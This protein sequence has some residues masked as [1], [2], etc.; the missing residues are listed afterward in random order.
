VLLAGT[1]TVVTLAVGTPAHADDGCPNG[2]SCYYDHWGYAKIWTAPSCGWFNLGTFVPPL[3]DRISS[4][5]NRGNGAVQGYNWTGSSWQPI[6]D[7][8]AADGVMV[9][10]QGSNNNV[11]DGVAIAC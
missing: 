6:G 11:I 10:Y 9:M 2:Y 3:N 7:L 4:V 1:P 5:V 8:V